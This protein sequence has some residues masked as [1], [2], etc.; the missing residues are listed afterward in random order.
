MKSKEESPVA[1][2]NQPVA[3]T[4][5]DS[6]KSQIINCNARSLRS[7]TNPTQKINSNQKCIV[8]ETNQITISH[9]YAQLPQF[10]TSAQNHHDVIQCDSNI[11][12]NLARS[13]FIGREFNRNAR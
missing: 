13:T 10:K 11:S 8:I 2:E 4:N 7:R 12:I 1:T 5:I 3:E 9:W 6:I